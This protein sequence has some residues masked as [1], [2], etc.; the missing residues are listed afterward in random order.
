MVWHQIGANAFAITLLMQMW[1]VCNVPYCPTHIPTCC[2]ERFY[3]GDRSGGQHW[4]NIFV[5]GGFIFSLQW[6]FYSL[7][8]SSQ[9]DLI[10]HQLLISIIILWGSHVLSSNRHLKLQQIILLE[11]YEVC[12]QDSNYSISS[13][14]NHM[15]YVFRTQITAYHLVRIIWSMYSGLKLQHIIL[16]E[17]Y[18]V[19]IQDSN[20]SISSC[21][22]H[23]KY[24][25]RTQITAYHLV[26]IIWSMYSGLKLQHIILLESY[27]VC[28]QDSN[29]FF[30]ELNCTVDFCYNTNNNCVILHC[31]R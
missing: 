25:F 8:S 27:E 10:M 11:S 4:L 31:A 1:L 18:E 7:N 3:A 19:C 28:I 2:S 21:W 5:F 15:K 16:L 29:W 20:Y 23:M 12:I 22:N 24:V 9:P 26:R 6:R 30:H 13:C 17:S 14:W